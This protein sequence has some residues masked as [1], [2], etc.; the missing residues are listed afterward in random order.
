LPE[1]TASKQTKYARAAFK[2][3]T[4]GIFVLL[5][6]ILSSIAGTIRRELAL[7]LIGAVFLASWFYCFAMTLLLALLHSRRALRISLRISPQEISAGEC[8]DVVYSDNAAFFQLPGI[9]VRCRLL[10]ATTDGRRIAHDF[11]PS[12]KTALMRQETFE[13]KN[14]GAY[15]SDYDELAIFDI[16]GFFRFA[17]RI[18]H[19]TGVRLLASPGAA[20]SPLPVN[21]RS[22]E[23]SRQPEVTLIRTDNLIDHRPY[24]PGDDPRRINWKLYGHG[25]ELFVREG[26][27]EPPPHSNIVILIDT[28]F[29][30]ML[31]TAGM[32]RNGTD[33]LCENGLAAGL[34]CAANGLNVQIGCTSKAESQEAKKTVTAAEMAAALAWPAAIPLSE[35]AHL[36]AASNDRGVLILAMPRANAQQSALDRF[37]AGHAGRNAGRS[38]APAVE[39][40]F[41]YKSDAKKGITAGS[42]ELAGAAETCAG[43]YGRRPGV[44]ARAI[45]L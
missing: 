15:F 11:R 29:D 8:T 36:P 41:L 32:A 5:I 14:R 21:A 40:F 16:L 37:L 28:Q 45:G 35:A 42:G 30:K 9:L 34:A 38:A 33:L 31:Y 20:E 39:I 13:V 10:L 7:T 26:E 12:K 27:R 23:S 18:P 6:I 19:G 43:V 17:F 2:P 1:S 22:G 24:V 4:M 44:R 3:R 25:G